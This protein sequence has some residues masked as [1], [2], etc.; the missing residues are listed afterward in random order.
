MTLSKLKKAKQQEETNHKKKQHHNKCQV[1]HRG[2]NVGV[3]SCLIVQEA[4]A[5]GGWG[6]ERGGMMLLHCAQVTPHS[7]ML[8][9][10]D[11]IAIE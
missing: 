1:T 2:K 8:G 10:G 7:S 5:R 3:A 4:R 6:G 11:Y 9:P